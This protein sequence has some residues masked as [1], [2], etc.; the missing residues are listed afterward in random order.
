MKFKG[1]LIILLI[2]ASMVYSSENKMIAYSGINW[3]LD[4]NQALALAE[5]KNK[6]V[7]IMFQ[8]AIGCISCQNFGMHIISHPLMAEVITNNFVPLIVFDPNRN[9]GKMVLEQLG[10][11][12]NTIPDMG[13]VNSKGQ[14]LVKAESSDY[15][16]SSFTQAIIRALEA[17]NKEIPE[18]LKLLHEDFLARDYPP[19]EEKT[20]LQQNSLLSGP[21]RYLP[22]LESQKKQINIALS[23]N[24]DPEPFLSPRQKNALELIQNHSQVSWDEQKSD[25]DF[26]EAWKKFSQKMYA[27]K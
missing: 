19:L 23:N 14:D 20:P 21:Y 4:Y 25:Q 18:Y 24:Q 11:S 13:I 12:S 3:L 1:I 27:I 10:N 8:G 16:Y 7:I 17:D 6:P 26:T 2:L 9:E 5:E 15:N 22:L